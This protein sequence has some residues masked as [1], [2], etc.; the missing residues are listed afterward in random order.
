MTVNLAVTETGRDDGPILVVLHGL[1]GSARNWAGL[2]QRFA[3]HH[4]VLAL[5]LRNHGCS[6]WAD[7]M[8]YADMADDVCAVLEARVAAGAPKHVA[9][10][11]H[12]MGGKVAM[13]LA[14][15]RPDWVAQVIVV[16]IAPVTY[17]HSHATI[18][19]AMRALDLTVMTRR[20]DV[21]RALV[22]AVPEAGTRTFLLQNLVRNAGGFAWRLNLA[23]ID[24][25]MAGLTGFPDLADGVCYPGPALFIRGERSDYVQPDMEPR[26]QALFPR[27][28]IVTIAGAAHWVHADAPD[29]L[30]SAV[31]AF[32]DEA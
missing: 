3:V 20:A 14:L 15:R 4:R 13:M 28:R 9:V 16:D 32:L 6:P 31:E 23:A 24:A 12:S 22:D 8:G 7:S 18:V 11:G 10:L 21:E 5:D 26:I 17:R 1:F 19:A 30:A 29:A 25:E 2:A 27:A